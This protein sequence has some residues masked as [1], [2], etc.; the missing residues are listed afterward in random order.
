M[1][2]I[3]ITLC[4]GIIVMG[5]ISFIMYLYKKIFNILLFGYSLPFINI[6]LFVLFVIPIWYL[7]QAVIERILEIRKGESDDLS[8]Y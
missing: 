7:V 2:N 6:F 1:K 8:K 4:I 5:I 3:S